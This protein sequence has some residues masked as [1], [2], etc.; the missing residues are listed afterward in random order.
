MF[1]EEVPLSERL[2]EDMMV[3]HH[4]ID[5]ALNEFY[6]VHGTSIGAVDKIC[7]TGL[8]ERIASKGGFFGKGIYVADMTCMWGSYAGLLYGSEE[9]VAFVCRVQLG[10]PT[11]TSEVTEPRKYRGDVE[12]PKY[13]GCIVAAKDGYPKD[14]GPPRKKHIHREFIVFKREQVYPEFV[15][16]FKRC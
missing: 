13:D 7:A 12:A 1:R 6:F 14:F 3:H 8:D 2:T 10:R 5:P 15:V 4:P 11:F 16:T 9:M